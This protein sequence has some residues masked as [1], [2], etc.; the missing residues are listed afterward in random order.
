MARLLPWKRP[1]ITMNHHSQN[2]SLITTR[3]VHQAILE[4][5]IAIRIVAKFH[6]ILISP[7]QTP[8]YNNMKAR[9]TPAEMEFLNN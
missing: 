4:K 2:D 7:S 6:F 5:K 8:Q 1:G 9:V 3:E